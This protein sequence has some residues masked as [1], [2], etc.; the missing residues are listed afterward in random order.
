MNL[1]NSNTLFI[2]KVA[3]YLKNVDSTNSYAKQLL[4]KSN[5]IEGTVIY[6]ANQ[7]VGRGQIGSSW[8]S[9]PDK[10]LLL[11]IILYPRFLSASAQFMLNKAVCLAAT[12]VLCGMGLDREQVK[13]KWPNDIY[14]GARKIGGI[15][16]ENQL[17]GNNL[18]HSVIG[19]GLNINQIEFDSSLPNPTSVYLQIGKTK[20]ITTTLNHYCESLEPYYLQLKAANHRSINRYYLER[21]LGYQE[22]R[23]FYHVASKKRI[24]AK[25]LGVN[26]SGQLCLQTADNLFYCS[27]KEISFEF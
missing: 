11:S 20:D 16:I 2:G 15:L 24:R 18:H 10:N 14:V 26:D 17:K 13:I 22:W 5:P 8:Q 23:N 9:E 21:M 6:A 4:S 27:L 7:Q 1:L 3:K 12:D 25:I 19:L